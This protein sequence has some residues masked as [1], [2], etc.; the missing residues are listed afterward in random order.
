MPSK[1]DMIVSLLRELESVKA[2]LSRAETDEQKAVLETALRA[3]AADLRWLGYEGAAPAK[4][5]E[6]RPVVIPE[7]RG[8]GRP[9]KSAE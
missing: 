8:P 7:K 3:G 5:A 6:I 4:R 9:R 2:Q 1:E